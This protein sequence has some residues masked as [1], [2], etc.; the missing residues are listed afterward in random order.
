MSGRKKLAM[1]TVL[2]R[3]SFA[4]E[5]EE[6]LDIEDPDGEGIVLETKLYQNY[7]NPFNPTTTL[8][9]RLLTPQHVTL[10]VYDLLGREVAVLLAD[11]EFDEGFHEVEF[12]ATGFASGVYFCRFQTEPVEPEDAGATIN[13]RKL[14]LLK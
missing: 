1:P 3:T 7:P 8:G 14:L 5:T 4:T 10:K 13:V 11:E 12:D 9:F 2:P 6:D